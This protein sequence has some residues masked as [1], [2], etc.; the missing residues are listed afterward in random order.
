MVEK[1]LCTCVW[2]LQESD[3]LG[4]SVSKSTCTRHIAKQKNTWTNSTDIPVL[5]RYLVTPTSSS[6][7]PVASSSSSLTMPLHLLPSADI[8]KENQNYNE[9]FICDFNSEF[10][11]NND[12][13]DEKEV[14]SDRDNQSEILES[15]E[16]SDEEKRMLFDNYYSQFEMLES[17]EEEN[18]EDDDY[19]E[20]DD[21]DE[22]NN[23]ECTNFG[24]FI[25]FMI[26]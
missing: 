1:V 7:I 17:D 19:N 11:R 5:Q 18:H 6:I 10:L 15:D 16:E 9:E 23:I 22:N 14:Q 8:P 21:N 24:K 2:C 25:Y 12:I 4:K 13:N 26:H 20:K 3:G